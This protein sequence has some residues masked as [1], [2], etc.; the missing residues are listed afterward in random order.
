LGEPIYKVVTQAVKLWE[1]FD[2]TVFK[3][4]KEKQKL[5]V[6]ERKKEVFGK[7]NQDF[8]KLGLE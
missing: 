1:E 2:N 5:W 8:A 4:T 6:A 3:L 7:L